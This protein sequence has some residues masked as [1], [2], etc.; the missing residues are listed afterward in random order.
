MTQQVDRG[1]SGAANVLLPVIDALET[2]AD[3]DAELRQF[4]EGLR[5]KS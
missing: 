1:S 4:L 2:L 3:D 5:P